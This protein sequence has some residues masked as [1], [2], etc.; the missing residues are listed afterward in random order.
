MKTVDV[1]LLV[2]DDVD[3]EYLVEQLVTATAGV[4]AP[5]GAVQVELVDGHSDGRLEPT[6]RVVTR[7]DTTWWNGEQVLEAPRQHDDTP[8]ETQLERVQAL[9]RQLYPL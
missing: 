3:E 4:G 2:P 7:H 9:A 5:R 6:G 8:P 1:R